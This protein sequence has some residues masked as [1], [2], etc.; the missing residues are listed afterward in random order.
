MASS[1][2]KKTTKSPKSNLPTTS[3]IIPIYNEAGHLLEFLEKV[4]AL[5]IPTAKELVFIDDCSKD[6][7]RTILKQF[8]FRSEHQLIFQ[9][10]NQGKGAALRRG[11]QAAKGDI[12]IVQDADFE[13]DMEEIPMLIEPVASGKADVVF[14]SRFK[15]DGRQVHRT[16]HY[17]INRFLTILSNFLSGLYL[18]DM[19]TCYKVFKAE[20]IK[21]I[22]LESNRFGFEPEVTAKVGRLKVRVQEFPISYYP[23]NYLEGKKITWKDGVAAL[24]HIIY[25]NW[26]APKKDFFTKNIPGKYIPRGANW[27]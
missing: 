10:K 8:S 3:L 19:E 13:Y 11:I 6:E 1:K 5:K 27:L 16:F 9:E 24:R 21:N 15:K 22:H 4:D 25:Y 26:F 17:L 18:T 12:I 7:S 14:G 20:I 23:R 2:I